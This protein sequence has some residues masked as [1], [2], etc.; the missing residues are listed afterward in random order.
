[1]A[2]DID[3]G[4]A[5]V[6]GT[7][8]SASEVNTRF[9]TLEASIEDALSA[10]AEI[11]DGWQVLTTNV[12]TGAIKTALELEWDPSDGSNLTDNAS[13]LSI[14]VVLPTSTD[15]Q[16]AFAR[17]VGMVRDDTNGAEEGE[18]AFRVLDGGVDTEIMTISG[19]GITLP[20]TFGIPF[21]LGD[22]Y[23]WKDSSGNIRVKSGSAAASQDETGA[24]VKILVWSETT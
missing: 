18:V 12:A 5:L 16:K 6:D 8:N 2:I 7:T 17:L 9:T 20:G 1:M 19:A 3:V 11:T 14:D 15:V 24:N 22:L 13:G 10:L 21:I 23:F 4:D